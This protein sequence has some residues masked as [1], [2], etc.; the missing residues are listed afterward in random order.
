MRRMKNKFWKFRASA[1]DPKVGELLL[2]GVIDSMTW[3]G[4]EITPK[5]FKKELD[6]L[7]DVE[8][9]KVFI[10]SEGG[11]V[12]AGQAIHSMLKRHR[13]RIE[14]YIDGLAASIASVVAMAGD[15]IR[16]PKNAMMM[17]HNP[18]TIAMGTADDFRK[19]AD[20]MDQIRESIIVTYQDKTGMDRE[21]II[22]LMD[23]ETWMTAE[24]AVQMGFADELEESKKIAASLKE[25]LLVVNGQQFDLTKYKNP[26]KIV[27]V[28]QENNMELENPREGEQT[29]EGLLFLYQKKIQINKNRI[30]GMK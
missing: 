19:L 8:L 15:I 27:V 14:V 10:N 11:D 7:G 24:E 30:G 6:D 25:G 22:R 1:D 2:Y 18:W 3:W 9:I 4:D 29:D 26:P 17:V 23:E 5:Q 13:A 12:F 28:D 21:E 16:M 20:D